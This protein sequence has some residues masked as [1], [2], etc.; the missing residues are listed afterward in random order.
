MSGMYT[1][2]CTSIGKN[3]IKKGLVCQDYSDN[4]DSKNYSAVF[5]ADGH[6]SSN[7]IRSDRGARFACDA[8]KDAVNDF[9]NEFI[10]ERKGDEDWEAICTQ[11]CKNIL[12]RW[13]DKVDEDFQKE[14]FGVVELENV[15]EKYQAQYKDG[16]KYEHAYG[17]T[18]LA[19][20]VTDN[21]TIALRNGDG[22][23]ME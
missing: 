19:V 17:T 23:S 18:L 5:V 21:Y 14:P 3:H 15:S 20:I 7:C 13:H 11:L 8:A 4:V 22:Y 2:A 12:L 9:V 1:F 10:I 6:G 16:K